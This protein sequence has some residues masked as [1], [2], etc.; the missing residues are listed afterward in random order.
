MN[1]LLWL[2]AAYVAICIAAWFG[3]RVFM[4]FP[5]P[6]RFTPAEVGLSGVEEVELASDGETLIVWYAKADPGQP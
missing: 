4:Y 1:T 6:A 5:D 2:I 3:N